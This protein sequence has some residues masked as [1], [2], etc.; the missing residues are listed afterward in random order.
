MELTGVL[1]FKTVYDLVEK[2]FRL[3]HGKDFSQPPGQYLRIPND[4]YGRRIIAMPAYLGGTIQTWGTKWIASVPNNPLS[5]GIERASGLLILN[6]VETGLPVAVIEGGLISAYRTAAVALLAIR[7]LAPQNVLSIGI[8]G[9]GFIAKAIA[10][11]LKETK[12]HFRIEIYDPVQK[13]M[14]DFKQEIAELGMKTSTRNSA[15][16]L[17]SSNR[18]VA[19][20]TTAT[21]PYVEGSWLCDGSLFINISLRDPKQDVVLRSDKVVVDDWSESIRENTVLCNMVKEKKI[22]RNSLHAE[23][24]EIVVG[25]K[26]GRENEEETIFFNPMGMSIEDIAVASYVYREAEKKNLGTCINFA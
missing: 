5:R 3:H 20:A 15:K 19:A 7:H 2:A 4:V 1:D 23:L 24:G 22:D 14:D 21:E 18:I 11:A 26:P 8:L 10:K 25:S 13:R 12:P 9:A 6:D 16:E 17:V